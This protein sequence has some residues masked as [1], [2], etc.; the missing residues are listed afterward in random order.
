MPA[1]KNGKHLQ[2]SHA[3]SPPLLCPQN[4][5]T[6][7]AGGKVTPKSW[8]GQPLVIRELQRSGLLYFFS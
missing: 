4:G 7:N 8:Q 5:Q 1:L 6:R 3:L 2:S